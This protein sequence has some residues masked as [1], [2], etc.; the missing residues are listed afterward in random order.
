MSRRGRSSLAR[1][2]RG[3]YSY[4]AM[5]V[6]GIGRVIFWGGGSLWIGQAIAPAQ[7]HRHHAI[8]VCIGFDGPIQFRGRTDAPWISYGGALIAPDLAHEFR[9]PG[10]QVGNILFAPE[11]PIGQALLERY[12]NDSI[13]RIPDGLAADVSAGLKTAWAAG[14]GDDDLA[15]HAQALLNRLAGTASAR[16]RADPRILK[17]IDRISHHLDGPLRLA[18]VA[19]VA[20]LSEGRFRHLFVAETGIAFRPYILWTRLNRALELGFGGTTWTEA[21]HAANFSDQA[22]LIRTCRRM[23]GLV[24][25]SLRIDITAAEQKIPV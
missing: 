1:I 16:H 9:A 4:I 15:S 5:K 25:T 17:S 21:A 10:R 13:A 24:P 20:G 14:A 3:R 11:T 6:S 22:H 19:A 12:S 2:A 18:D 8:Q 23:L 7:L